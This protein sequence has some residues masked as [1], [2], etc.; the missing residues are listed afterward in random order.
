MGHLYIAD[1]LMHA[2]T[3]ETRTKAALTKFDSSLIDFGVSPIPEQWKVD[4]S[5]LSEPVCFLYMSGMLE[6]PKA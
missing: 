3:T 1:P 5:C 4:N 6:W 2:L